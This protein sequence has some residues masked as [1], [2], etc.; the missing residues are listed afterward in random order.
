[1]TYQ[2]SAA[3]PTLT[4]TME[5]VEEIT[6]I[7]KPACEVLDLFTNT[8]FN[9]PVEYTIGSSGFNLAYLFEQTTE[10]VG[11]LMPMT[12]TL[13]DVPDRPNMLTLNSNALQLEI[14]ESLDLT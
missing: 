14:A 2:L 9:D 8:V 11:C 3:D 6:I 7:V 4:D 5:A 12:Y 1:M 13:T 10:P